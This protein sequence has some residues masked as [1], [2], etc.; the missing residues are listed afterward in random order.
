MIDLGT[1][2]SN[3]YSDAVAVNDHGQVVGYS[4]SAAGSPHAF[5]WTARGGMVDLDPF[6][7]GGYSL[8]FAVNNRGQIVGSIR[9][10]LE[11]ATLWRLR[12]HHGEQDND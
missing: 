1:L 7:S 10:G 12:R 4:S 6:L 2:G 11:H 5:S 3:N 8:A 9:L